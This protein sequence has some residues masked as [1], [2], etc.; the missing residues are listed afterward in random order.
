M[1]RSKYVI[2]GVISLT[3]LAVAGCKKKPDPTP[4]PTV[5]PAPEPVPEVVVAA[6]PE[7]VIQMAQN[8]Q[9]LLFELDSDVL[10]EEARGALTENVAIMQANPKIKIQLQGHA[11]ERGT[12]DYNL[13]LGQQRADAV[14]SYM[15]MSGVSGSR[16]TVISY[17]EES[18]LVDGET[19]QAWSQNRRCEFIITWGSSP[20]IGGS[21]Q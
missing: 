11:D 12:T 13:A 21:D 1:C 20:L 17:G 10:S 2:A 3:L 15:E 5:E 4:E 6:A 18:P 8:F 9:R 19:E 7:P 14:R 16:L